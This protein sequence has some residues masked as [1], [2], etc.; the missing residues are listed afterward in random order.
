M[1]GRVMR[2]VKCG[3]YGAGVV[4][5]G[6]VELLRTQARLFEAQGVRFVVKA[7][8]SRDTQR[9]RD[10][11]IDEGTVRTADPNVIL[12]DPEIDMVVEVRDNNDRGSA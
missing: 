6:V 12:N 10:F 1:A 5:G 2:T 7:I 3:I 4:G 11:V 9:A 8:C